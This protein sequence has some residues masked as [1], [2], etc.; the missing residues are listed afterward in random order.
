ML[1]DNKLGMSQH[2]DNMFKKTNSKLGI[3]CQ[4]RRFITENT[5]AKIYKTMIGPHLEYI[6]FVIDSCSKDRID[7]INKLENRAL[8]R[9]EYCMR[10]EHRLEYEEF[11]TKYKIECLSVWHKRSLLQKMY[12][13]SK[14]VNNIE[15]I[16]H[17]IN[18]RSRKKV[19][20][21][22]NSQGS[23]NYMLAHIIVDAAC[24]I[25]F[26]LRSK[27]LKISMYFSIR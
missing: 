13:K 20:M 11:K 10:L 17:D 9:T 21:K 16:S 22:Q 7:Q 12:E 14:N 26:L 1:L 23:Q 27:S 6:Y 3:L 15:A 18:L 19:K 25:S 8:R 5:A 2:V 4:I 24:G